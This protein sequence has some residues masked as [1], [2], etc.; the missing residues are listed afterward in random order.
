MTD[1]ECRA[2]LPSTLPRRDAGRAG[3]A[4]P[5]SRVLFGATA[6]SMLV[7]GWLMFSLASVSGP[8]PEG[9]RA[10]G[11]RLYLAMT[12][13]VPDEAHQPT[14]SSSPILNAPPTPRAEGL[15]I[16]DAMVLH[17]TR[18]AH[19]ADEKVPDSSSFS[20]AR[21]DLSQDNQAD[22]G[23]FV[24]AAPVPNAATERVLPVA[25]SHHGSPG[26]RD[27][28]SIATADQYRV[29]LVMQARREREQLAVEAEGRT[30]VRLNFASGGALES[31]NVV[32][33][34]G[35]DALDAEALRLFDRARATLPVP[36]ALIARRFSI[37]AT[38]SFE[39]N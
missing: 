18:R 25:S 9:S 27:R 39:R 8:S 33:S 6:V 24:A 10:N 17:S 3:R 21:A 34:S 15:A 35:F 16:L 30:R 12:P 19:A 26:N 5:Q 29:A 4:R 14:A 28:P 20:A 32:T 11:V 2:A 37:E 7:H 23:T 36:E 31:A 13:N 1:P 22:P 38:V